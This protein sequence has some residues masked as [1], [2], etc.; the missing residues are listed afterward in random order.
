M[1][2]GK[3]ESAPE[4]SANHDRGADENVVNINNHQQIKPAIIKKI[5]GNLSLSRYFVEFT[6]ERGKKE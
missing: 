3:K 5:K 4:R 1:N 6:E 2:D